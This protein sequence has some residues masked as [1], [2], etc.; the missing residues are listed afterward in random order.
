M[1]DIDLANIAEDRDE[2]FTLVI[3]PWR[4]HVEDRE[5]WLCVA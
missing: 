1:E 3:R 5:V 2:F 4:V